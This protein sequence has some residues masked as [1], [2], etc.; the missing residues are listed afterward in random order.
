VRP[1]ALSYEGHEIPADV[2]DLVDVLELTPETIAHAGGGRPVLDREQVARLRELNVHTPFTIH[3]VS[4]SIGSAD[5]WNEAYLLLLDQ[6][7]DAFPNIL[8]HSEHLGFTRVDGVELCTMLPIPCTHESLDLVSTRVQRLIRRYERPFL[9]EPVVNL[10]PAPPGDMPEWAYL[11]AL[12]SRTGCRLL[13]DAYNLVCDRR[14]HGRDIDAF[15]H[16]VDL[17]YVRE[18]H[19][20]GG[21]AVDGV[22]LDVHTAV[23][24]GET[25]AVAEQVLQRRP[26]G[27][28]VTFEL[29]REGYELI[30]SLLGDEVRTIRGWLDTVCD[31]DARPTSA[32]A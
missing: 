9:V 6:C 25:L 22:Q 29:L 2:I 28:L 23:P 20:A 15:L 19:I 12:T 7:F 10:L 11:N 8:W 4:L 16:H 13:L 14:N 31:D 32:V 17:R 24:D 30:G 21:V 27:L 3:G 1:L 5:A 18:L 26:D